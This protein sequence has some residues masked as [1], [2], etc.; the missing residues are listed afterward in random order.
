MRPPAE[1]DTPPGP[2]NG[3]GLLFMGMDGLTRFDFYLL[4][5][6]P[7]YRA[8][9]LLG[10]LARDHTLGTV[11]LYF[12][13]GPLARYEAIAA[14]EG[15]SDHL[16]VIALQPPVHF[17]LPLRAAFDLGARASTTPASDGSVFVVAG[18]QR[19]W[20]A[21]RPEV[22]SMSLPLQ[23]VPR[24][25]VEALLDLG[26]SKSSVVDADAIGLLKRLRRTRRESTLP[27]SVWLDA[28]IEDYPALAEPAQRVKYLGRRRFSEYAA[29]LGVPNED[30]QFSLDA[31]ARPRP[32]AH[33]LVQIHRRLAGPDGRSLFLRWSNHALAA[34]PAL[35]DKRVRQWLFGV[36]RME[37]VAKACG[38]QREGQHLRLTHPAY[39]TQQEKDY[40]NRNH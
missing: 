36:R 34:Y 32:T 35:H 27:L 13:A 29:C 17:G 5:P 8:F 39:A 28:L 37:E 12:D 1:G 21:I 3:P 38:L 18:H 23:Y 31:K 10:S 30:G 40:A 2:R 26:V 9:R 14:E 22:H 19:A 7:D 16:E 33:R 15:F 20:Q 25:T 6:L 24:L 4:T 11:R